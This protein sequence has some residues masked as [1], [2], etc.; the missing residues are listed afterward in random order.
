ML[1]NSYSRLLTRGMSAVIED[2]GT[3]TKPKSAR[4]RWPILRGIALI[5]ALSAFI[6]DLPFTFYGAGIPIA[7]IITEHRRPAQMTDVTRRL[8]VLALATLA[9][10]AMTPPG[11][12][13]E[14]EGAG[15]EMVRQH[16]S[17]WP[18]LIDC[19]TTGVG[20]NWVCAFPWFSRRYAVFS[21]PVVGA[22]G[23]NFSVRCR[24]RSFAVVADRTTRRKKFWN[25]FEPTPSGSHRCLPT[26]GRSHASTK[27]SQ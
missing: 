2:Q 11:A 3:V 8:Q 17:P 14:S 9:L 4:F 23:L 10:I 20:Y 13:P 25:Y 26:R 24:R 12:L 27:H 6:A 1:R 16:R 18:L 19:V 22:M 15:P 7:L 5:V 21:K